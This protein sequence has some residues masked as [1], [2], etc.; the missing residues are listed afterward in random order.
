MN[1]ARQHQ[2]NLD[3]SPSRLPV[4]QRLAPGATRARRNTLLEAKPYAALEVG[5]DGTAPP[6]F[7]VQ[8]QS[9]RPLSRRRLSTKIEELYRA[10][11]ME[12]KGEEG[13]E[14]SQGQEATKAMTV[15]ANTVRE[16]ER[17]LTEPR[18]G[19]F[20]DMTRSKVAAMRRLFSPRSASPEVPCCGLDPFLDLDPI[21]PPQK[22]KQIA[23]QQESK[24]P[25]PPTPPPLPPTKATIVPKTSSTIEQIPGASEVSNVLDK[26]KT[27]VSLA[28]SPI[29]VSPP[30]SKLIAEKVKTFETAPKSGDE[31]VQPRRG[32]A[33]RR[34]LSKSLRSLFEA[35]SRRSREDELD[36]SKPVVASAKP[37]R[38]LSPD[39]NGEISSR[40]SI[41]G[42][43]NKLPPNAMSSG[44]D[45]TASEKRSP[46]LAEEGEV[47]EIIIKGVECGLKEPRPVRATEMKRMA[48]LCRDRMEEIIDREKGRVSQRGKF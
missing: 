1:S 27:D 18:A 42:R 22:P 32:K 48:L 47:A 3:V 15:E 43:W 28:A 2:S 26:I 8:D 6:S 9:S 36:K 10:K 4:R 24:P 39:G 33:L 11:N 34:R 29:K 41:V 23:R 13:Q 30:K 7:A 44:G 45:G 35:P 5:G 31:T 14:I 21:S 16:L 19:K 20:S 46:S 17:R 12:K 38:A 25:K 40:G 37:K